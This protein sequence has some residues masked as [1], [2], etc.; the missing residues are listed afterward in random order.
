MANKETFVQTLSDILVEHK[1]MSRERAQDLQ[2]AYGD[3]SIEEYD[4]FLLEEGLVSKDDLLAALSKYYGVPSYDV[5]P[6]FFN[7]LVAGIS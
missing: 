2:K 1:V 3:S 4:D 6:E 5:T 7:P